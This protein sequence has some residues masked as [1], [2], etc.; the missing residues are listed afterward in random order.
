VSN[1]PH[2]AVHNGRCAEHAT[3]SGQYTRPDRGTTTEQGYGWEWQKLREA[4]LRDNPYCV[5]CMS[6]GVITAARVVDHIV[7]LRQGGSSD[8]GNLQALCDRC[9]NRKRQREGR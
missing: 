7:P 8:A 5:Q 6:D 4:Y 1:C 3:S 2:R 9:H